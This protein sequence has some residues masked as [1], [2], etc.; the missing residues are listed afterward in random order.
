MKLLSN[1]LVT[2]TSRLLFSLET[3]CNTKQ[4]KVWINQPHHGNHSHTLGHSAGATTCTWLNTAQHSPQ[5]NKEFKLAC[6]LRKQRQCKTLCSFTSHPKSMWVL[7]KECYYGGGLTAVWW[8]RRH[9]AKREE[10]EEEEVE[11]G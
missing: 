7:W 10:E 1:S 5:R 3:Q 8:P 4:I 6:A 2:S 11:T 9:R